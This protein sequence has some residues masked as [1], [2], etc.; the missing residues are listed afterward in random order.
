MALVLSLHDGWLEMHVLAVR[1]MIATGCHQ[2]RQNEA[3]IDKISADQKE[4]H[5]LSHIEIAFCAAVPLCCS[6]L[7]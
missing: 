7:I 3:D 5:T 1:K 6:L 2:G 4:A